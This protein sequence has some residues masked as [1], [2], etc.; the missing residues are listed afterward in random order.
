MKKEYWVITN[1][2]IDDKTRYTAN[3]YLQ[4][5]KLQ[6]H[7]ESTIDKYRRIL[8][9]CFIGIAK[10]IG[11]WTSDD[12][13]NWINKF[14]ADKK[15]KTKDMII[16]VLSSFFNYC[17]SEGY[18]EKTLI[19]KR[20]RPK[21]NDTLPKYLGDDELAVTKLYAEKQSLRDRAIFLFLLS[22]GCRR[23][24]LKMLN[25]E[26]ID[27]D[28]RT[29]KVIGKGKKIRNVHI[30]PECAIVL[31][32]YL[33]TRNDSEPALF[34]NKNGKRLGSCG[35]YHTTIKIGKMAGL[36]VKL[37]PHL[38]RHTFATCL[39]SRGADLGFIGDELG[40]NN[41][42]TT[43]IYAS[44]LSEKLISEYRKIKE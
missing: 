13:L 19:K 40:H 39:L 27:I 23:T 29:A 6:G 18:I 32:E 38:L 21:I 26:D 43:R 34:L 30:S 8:E 15:P 12:V 2:A 20:W 28:N 1:N 44:V 16:N 33:T 5:I 14:Y 35:I 17:E 9:R 3:E 4:K 25:K 11:D 31:R 42:S 24:E 10:P 22:S 7:S 36:Q 37:H 41:H